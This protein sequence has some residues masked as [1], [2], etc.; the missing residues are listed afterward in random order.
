[1]DSLSLAQLAFVMLVF[2]WSGFVRSALGFGG[3][4]LAL[5]LFLL[6]IDSPIEVLPII[7]IHLV[8]FGSLTVGLNF[9]SVDWTYLRK[10]IPF[11]LPFKIAGV[12]GLL[13][14]PSYILIGMVYTV[15]MVYGLSYLIQYKP[16]IRTAWIDNISLALGSYVS[17]VALIGAPLMVGVIAKHVDKLRLRDTLFM[18]WI[19]VVIIKISGFLITGTDLNL[20]WTFYTLPAVTVGH[21]I[22]VKVHARIINLSQAYFMRM[23]GVLLLLFCLVGIGKLFIE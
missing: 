8:I 9:K 1:M 14:L 21:Y 4:A 13:S 16:K 20:K 3:A 6:V 12:I 18:L 19:F 5:P 15:S 23:I 17:G 11:I 10:I 7:A 2:V 22:G